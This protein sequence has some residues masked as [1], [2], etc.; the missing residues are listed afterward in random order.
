MTPTQKK[1]ADE[2]RR[3][4]DECIRI[5]IMQVLHFQPEG[6]WDLGLL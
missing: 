5:C 1:E 4:L 3:L 2:I 6:L